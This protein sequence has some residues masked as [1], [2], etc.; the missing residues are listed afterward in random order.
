M[1][2]EV[3]IEVA[4]REGPEAN[5]SVMAILQ[6]DV[7]FEVLELAGDNAWGIA[8]EHGLVGYVNADSLVR[9]AP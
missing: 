7:I 2:M 8:L 6:P 4:L 5:S 9:P 3:A 1:P